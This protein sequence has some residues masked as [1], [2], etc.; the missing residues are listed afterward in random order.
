MDPHVNASSELG[1]PRTSVY[2]TLVYKD[3]K[4]G[5]HVSG[6]AERWDISDDGLT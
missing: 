6:L 1:I 2:D 3:P 5:T 4:T